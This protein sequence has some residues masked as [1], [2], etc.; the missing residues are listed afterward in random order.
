MVD[1]IDERR[2]RIAEIELS[3][4]IH[5]N[6]VLISRAIIEI[7]HINY[8]LNK[9]TGKLNYS[10]RTNFTVKQI[11]KFILILDGEDQIPL[12]INKSVSKF[13]IRIDC[14]I[15]GRFYNK[16]FIMIFIIDNTQSNNV[17]TVTLIPNW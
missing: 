12:S 11:E 3:R 9:T 5:F 8:G 15:R 7:D 14:P 13:A 10:A 4:K 2:G 6:G 16:E 1:R 17:H